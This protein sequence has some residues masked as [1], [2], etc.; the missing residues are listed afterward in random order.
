MKVEDFQ[1]QPDK[2]NRLRETDNLV[3][4]GLSRE[5]AE[6]LVNQLYD[7]ID[8]PWADLLAPLANPGNDLERG[9]IQTFWISYVHRWA[10]DRI[11]LAAL[12]Q[13]NLLVQLVELD[14]QEPRE[15]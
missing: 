3:A 10:G 8:G 9:L 2:A 5:R 4:E 13:Q 6:R 14:N 11:F 15:N 1:L 12:A 7:L